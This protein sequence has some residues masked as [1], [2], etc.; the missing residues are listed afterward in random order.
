MKNGLMRIVTISL[1]LLAGCSD[2]GQTPEATPSVQT[3]E[4]KSPLMAG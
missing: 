1:F 4:R 3:G 2:S